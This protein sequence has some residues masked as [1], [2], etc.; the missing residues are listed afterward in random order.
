MIDRITDRQIKKQKGLDTEAI[1][2]YSKESQI[3]T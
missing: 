1:L 3:S 2:I